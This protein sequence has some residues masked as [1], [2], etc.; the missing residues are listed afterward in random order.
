[1]TTQ[2]ASTSQLVAQAAS[3]N[4][5]VRE[6]AG[7][8]DLEIDLVEHKLQYEVDSLRQQLQESVDTHNLRIGYANKIF[9]LVCIWLACVIVG[10]LLAGFHAFGFSLSDKVLMTFIASTTINVLGLFAIV[11]KWMFQ[12][13]GKTSNQYK[14]SKI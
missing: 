6:E 5:P 9:W 4:K 12:Q 8:P 3:H 14:K 1:M 13:N 2:K 11:A 10:V 7:L